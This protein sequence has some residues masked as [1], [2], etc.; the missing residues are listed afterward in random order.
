MSHTHLGETINLLPRCVAVCCSALQCVAVY[1][2][3][4]QCV[5]VC[6]SVLQCAALC[7]K[8]LQY[9]ALVSR[10]GSLSAHTNESHTSGRHD[11]LPPKCVTVCCS[12]WQCVCCSLLRYEAQTSR[13]DNILPQGALATSNEN[14]V[15][16]QWAVALHNRRITVI[17]QI[18][19]ESRNIAI[20]R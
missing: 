16:R 4:L 14:A 15:I 10:R 9:E 13:H 20:Q 3:V 8:V 18:L 17:P 1:C 11:N 12:V 7:C 2:S 19:S 6:C 5:T